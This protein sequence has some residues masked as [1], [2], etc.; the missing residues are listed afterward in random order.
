MRILIVGLNFYPELTGIGKYTAEMAT[1]LSHAGHQIRVVTAPPYYPYWRVQPGYKSWQYRY[2]EWKGVQVY[3][4]PLW[5]PQEPSGMKR[6]L[7]LL[8]FAISSVPLLLW[9]MLWHPDLVLCIAPA[10]FSAPFAW[11]TA[12]L[13][14]AKSWLH[15]QDFELDAATN[16]G[17]LPSNNLLVKIASWGECWLLARFDRVS[18]ISD[19]MLVRLKEKGVSSEHS[20]LF[21]NWVDTNLIFPTKDFRDSLRT[22]LSIPDDK[23]VVLY[24]GNIGFK[25]GLECI[26]DVA[27][28]L[29]A[30]S[31]IIFVICGDG[32]AREMLEKSADELQNIQ[33][34]GL[35]PPEKLNQLLNTADIHILPQRADAADLVMP[36]KLLGMLASGRAVIATANPD[37]E[38]GKVVS[39]IGMIVPPNNSLAF[40]NAILALAESSE[41]R[42]RLGEKGREYICSHWSADQ[43]LAHFQV[44]LLNLVNKN[45]LI[46]GSKGNT[47]L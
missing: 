37:T 2:E 40:S 15:I 4:A 41:K 24:S 7:H 31:N 3:R 8:S 10:F 5:V 20:Y 13:S 38:I 43:V 12:R 26:V 29:Q 27:G 35:Q 25:Q 21:P 17:M 39:E 42:S 9:Q 28:Q 6:L 22:T 30:N 23:I 18:T 36:S 16:L 33:F 34:V 47:I 14:G 44:Q 19:R 46:V 32:A 11:L 1:Y 45:P